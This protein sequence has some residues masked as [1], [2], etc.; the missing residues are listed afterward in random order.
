MTS[1]GV[2]LHKAM[3][4]SNRR[5][6]VEEKNTEPSDFKYKFDAL[7]PKVVVYLQ[8]NHDDKLS[9]TAAIQQNIHHI[10]FIHSFIH[11]HS[12]KINLHNKI[13]MQD[14]RTTLVALMGAHTNKC[15]IP[16]VVRNTSH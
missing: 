7:R 13:K 5:F 2:T 6:T 4:H 12:N 16:Q 14:N 8:I 11:L 1:A 10:S 9:V 15:H 3:W